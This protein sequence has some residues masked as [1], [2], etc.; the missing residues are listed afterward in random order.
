[1]D[2]IA[3]FGVGGLICALVVIFCIILRQN[4]G[5]PALDWVSGMGIFVFGFVVTFFAAFAKEFI[6]DR[7]ADGGD[8]IASMLG[9]VP[10]LAAVIAGILCN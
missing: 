4:L 9:C 1:M 8:I 10:V 5:Q 2:K 6:I 3:H 7:T